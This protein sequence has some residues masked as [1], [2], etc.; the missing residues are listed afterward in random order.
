MHLRKL[1]YMLMLPSLV[2]KQSA[3]RETRK[4]AYRAISEVL[5]WP[6]LPGVPT[7]QVVVPSEGN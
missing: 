4:T 1:H 6:I 3:N 5:V 7:V 2:N